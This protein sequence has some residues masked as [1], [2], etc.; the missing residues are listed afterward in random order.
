MLFYI[1]RR[2]LFLPLTLLGISLIIFLMFMRLTPEQRVALYITGPE[3]LKGDSVE[4]IIELHGLRDPWHLQYGRWIGNVVRGN[5]G[6]STVGREPVFDALI[7]RFPYTLELAVLSGIPIIL[8]GIWLGVLSATNHN[9]P[10]DHALRISAVVGWSFPDFVFGFFVMMIFYSIL[11]WFPPGT[12]SY[13]AGLIVRSEQFRII[14]GIIT[15]DSLLNARFDVFLD[16]IR[17][18]AGPVLTLT[19]LGFAYILRI[20]R[21]AMLE[22]LEKDYVRTARAKGLAEGVVIYKHARRNA[23]IPVATESGQTIVALL[24]GTVIVETIFNRIGVGSFLAAAAQQLDFASVIG[25]SLLFGVI[26]V[27]GNLLVDISY[28]LIDP[29]IRLE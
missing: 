25:G 29:R 27:I 23:L 28:T 3:R 18:L 12:L 19:Y 6:W 14:T 4:R 21:S 10:L 17:R 13:E 16:A 15:L 8:L 24:G 7:R 9:R 20:T 5:L 11:G 2:L 1:I 22:V 26:L